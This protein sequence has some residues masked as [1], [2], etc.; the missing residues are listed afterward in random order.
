MI[1]IAIVIAFC[2]GLSF[3]WSLLGNK[4]QSGDSLPSEENYRKKPAK[5]TDDMTERM[6]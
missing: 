1:T 6:M 5:F 3:T 4:N 2:L